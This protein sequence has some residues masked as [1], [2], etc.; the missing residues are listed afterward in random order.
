MTRKRKTAAAFVTAAVVPI[1]LLLAWEAVVRFELVPPSQAAAPSAVADRLVALV[2]TGT[3]LKHTCVSL[4]RIGVGLLIG[5]SAG[6]VSGIL[7]ATSRMA[8]RL[9]SPTLHLLAGI[10]VVIWIPFWVMF[11]G[12]AE[13]FKIAMAAI[14]T[15]FLV[16][17]YTFM[18]VRSV[19]RG[20]L[21]LAAIY[22]KTTWE[23]IH[24]VLLPSAAPAIF[25]S[26]RTSL[27]FC[28][29]VI[30]FV[31]YASAKQGSEGLGWFIADSRQVGRIEEEFAGLL[32]LGLVAFLTDKVLGTL[33]RQML[34][35][36]DTLENSLPQEI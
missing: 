25:S 3:L 23:K 34:K 8:D 18:G 7:L 36:S 32:F 24:E 20:Y 2:L 22:E 14:S 19:G 6:I 30:F 5:A 35:W 29:V 11:F 12:T 10:P 17:L 9:F 13:A 31:E 16:H 4:V 26:I 28:W 21:E 33:Q 27:A 15:F 1:T